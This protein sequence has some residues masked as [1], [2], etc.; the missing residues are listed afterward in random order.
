MNNKGQVLIFSFIITLVIIILVYGLAPSG[1]EIVN[2]TI[3]SSNMD[4]GNSSISTFDKSACVA[5]D[6]GMF[7]FLIGLLTFAFA[8]FIGSKFK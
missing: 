4:C 3:H 8:I 1:F 2:Q 6:M 7:L 5:V